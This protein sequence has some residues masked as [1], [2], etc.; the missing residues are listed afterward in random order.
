M[1]IKN[2][3]MYTTVLL[4]HR[5]LC[6]DL[7]V[8]QAPYTNLFDQY[9][10]VA[11]LVAL[12]NGPIGGKAH[13]TSGADLQAVNGPDGASGDRSSREEIL[14]GHTVTG[15]QDQRERYVHNALKGFKR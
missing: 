1:C 9:S 13:T 3:Y 2:Y 7:H 11:R 15:G 8:N 12:L 5:H 4:L 10:R 6:R 14:N